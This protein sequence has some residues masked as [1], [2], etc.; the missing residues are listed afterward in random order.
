MCLFLLIPQI[1]DEGLSPLEVLL[2]SDK[3]E[4]KL[5]LYTICIDLDW[6]PSV[7]LWL[8]KLTIWYSCDHN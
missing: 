4:L 2:E 7:R 6:Y 1:M 8:S 3:L 5:G